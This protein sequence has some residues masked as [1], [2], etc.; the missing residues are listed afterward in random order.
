MRTLQ[1]GVALAAI[2]AITGA[3][4][5]CNKGAADVGSTNV[6]GDAAIATVNGA[7]ITS[8]DV[9]ISLQ[10]YRPQRPSADQPAGIVKLRLLIHN[11]VIEQ[12]AKK[13]GVY[14][15]DAQ[16]EEQLSNLRMVQEKNSVLPFDDQ[17]KL[18]GLNEDYIKRL[19]IIPQLCQLNILARG[20]TI[21]DADATAYYQRHQVD[22]FTKPERAHIKRMVLAS[23]A[24]AADVYAQLQKGASFEDLNAARSIDKQLVGGEVPQW[25]PLDDPHNPAAKPLFEAIRSTPPGKTTPPVKF[26]DSWW[27]VKIVDKKPR[28]VF[29]LASAKSMV[30]MSMMQQK[31]AAE[32]SRYTVLEQDWRNATMSAD[33][34]VTEPRYTSLVDELKNPPPLPVQSSAPPPAPAQAVAPGR[35]FPAAAHATASAQS[36]TGRPAQ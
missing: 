18:E 11:A 21:T 9:Y 15:T 28:E 34:E 24:D 36:P 4:A 17:L 31:I 32:P 5:G 35:N 2:A 12:M 20:I 10:A 23:E 19:Q 7:P 8:Q 22:M 25:L 1:R 6:P 33:I 13:E 16:V 29:D 30:R 3:L 27:I 26:Q 14:P